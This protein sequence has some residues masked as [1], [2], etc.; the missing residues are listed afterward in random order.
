MILGYLRSCNS[1]SKSY[2]HAQQQ[3]QPT[4]KSEAGFFFYST[5]PQ[6]EVYENKEYNKDKREKK[7]DDN[8][9]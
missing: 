7:E 3:L 5:Y 6:F 9:G 8:D 2:H 4:R 1:I